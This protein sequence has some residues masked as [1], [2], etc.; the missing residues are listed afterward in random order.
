VALLSY[1]QRAKADLL[2][3]WLWIAEDSQ[4]TADR[5]LAD[6]EHTAALLRD[7]PLLGVARSDIAPE[8]RSLVSNRWLILYRLEPSGVRIVR[9]VDGSRDLSK[10]L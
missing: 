8:A 2:D 3:I 10:I 1:S 6:I 4:A 7:N 5:V 9:V